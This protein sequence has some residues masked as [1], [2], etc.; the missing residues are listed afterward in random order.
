M[1]ENNISDAY[2]KKLLIAQFKKWGEPDL[3]IEPWMIKAKR[4]KRQSQ[5]RAMKVAVT[6]III[7]AGSPRS[8]SNR[9][10]Q[11]KIVGILI[12]RYCLK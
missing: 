2:I 7:T 8:G 1:T 3:K 11:S 4:A 5:N 10:S 6:R 12:R 9:S